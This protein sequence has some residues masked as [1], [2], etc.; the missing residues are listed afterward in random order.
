MSVVYSLKSLRRSDSNVFTQYTI[1]FITKT[2]LYSFDHPSNPTLPTR[3]QRVPTIYTLSRYMKNIRVFY[4]KIFSFFFFF[5]FL[6]VEFSIYLHRRVFVMYRSFL[7]YRLTDLR[8]RF[9]C[10]FLCVCVWGGG[11]EA[12]YGLM[13]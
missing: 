10:L 2:R 8:R 6:E 4:L 12:A 13:A 9:W 1:I 7:N 5:F 11:E 3:F